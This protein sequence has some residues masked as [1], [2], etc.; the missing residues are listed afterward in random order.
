MLLL[1][2]NTLLDWRALNSAK[3][4]IHATIAFVRPKYRF[5]G[6][7]LIE[8]LTRVSWHRFYFFVPALGTSNLRLKNY[9]GALHWLHL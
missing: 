3:A 7:A 9:A 5:T 1:A 8:K 6:F 2:T 4:A